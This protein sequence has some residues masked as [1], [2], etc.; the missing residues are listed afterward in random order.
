MDDDR[1]ALAR[2]GIETRRGSPRPLGASVTAQGCNFA[3]A[4]APAASMRLALFLPGGE[5]LGEIALDPRL[6]RTGD[7]WHVLVSGLPADAEYAWRPAGAGGAAGL[8]LDPYARAVAGAPRWGQDTAT[9]EAAA[10]LVRARRARVVDEV[11]DWGDDAPPDHHLADEIVYELHVRGYTAHPSSGVAHP[12]TFAGLIEKLP[13]LKELGVTAVELMP[14]MEFDESDCRRVDPETGKR[15]RNLWGYQPLAFLAPKAGYAWSGPER[16]ERREFR[17]LVRACHRAGIEVWLDVVFNHTGEGPRAAPPVSWRGLDERAYYLIDPDS[18]RD[19]DFTGCGNT[20]NC[21]HPLAADLIVDSLRHWVAEMH[22]DGFRFD[23]ASVLCRGR[24]GRPLRDP[25]LVERIG[26]D[27]L[28]SRAKLIAEPWDVGGLH[29]VGAFPGGGRWAEWNDRFRDDLRRFVRGDAGIAPLLA[30]RLSGSADLYQDDGRAPHHSLNFVTCHDGFTLRDLVSH[31]RRHNRRNAEDNRDGHA[32]EISWNGGCEGE[33]PD[34]ALAGLR[35]R[36]CKNLL[37]LLMV[38]QGTP[39]VLAG[40]EFGRTQGGNT[41]AWCQ[42][43]PTGWVDWGLLESHAELLRFFKLLV[44]LRRSHAL[45][46]RRDFARGG[47]MP[48]WVAWQGPLRGV[49]DWSP[50]VGLLG[51]HLRGHARHAELFVLA[52]ARDEAARVELPAAPSGT[53]WRRAVDTS[54]AAPEDACE[55]GREA[56]LSEPAEYLLAPHTVA[57]LVAR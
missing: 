7:V 27:P 31:A 18:G 42:D 48:D 15:L 43:N 47:A 12:G 53:C 49:P 35:L 17:E 1:E 29:Q 24:D 36:Q 46:R 14:V 56:P 34:P 40:D 20:F 10:S 32:G 11:V 13:Y 45:L 30:T 4:S 8:L 3:V 50:G 19:R 26:A 55:P 37:T 44:R 16:G 5:A 21:S 23:L 54:F 33:T 57:V 2:R 28:L 51:M 25:P 41:N 52:G 39:M 9:P 22:V 38:S 6:E